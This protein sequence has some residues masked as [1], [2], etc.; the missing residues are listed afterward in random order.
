[1]PIRV[2]VQLSVIFSDEL[3]CSTSKISLSEER[4]NNSQ[5][6]S[7]SYKGLLSSIWMSCDWWASF[8]SS[9]ENPQVNSDAILMVLR[10]RCIITWHAG[11]WGAFSLSS[12]FLSEG[13]MI[14]FFLNRIKSFNL[15]CKLPIGICLFFCLF[16]CLFV[17]FSSHYLR[18]FLYSPKTHWG[19]LTD[20]FK[21]I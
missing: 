11:M 20:W 15:E 7:W 14:F 2:K 3:V 19:D 18:F 4:R 10:Q 5:S 8:C 9:A 6:F 21:S 16:V 12:S 1:M 17:C 13:K